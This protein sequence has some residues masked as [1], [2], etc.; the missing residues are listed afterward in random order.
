MTGRLLA[1]FCAAVLLV[2]AAAFAQ[3]AGN[4]QYS[5]P[6]A[7]KAPSTHSPTAP[8]SPAPAPT[9]SSPPAQPQGQLASGSSPGTTTQ[10][11]SGATPTA[12]SSSALPRTGFDAWIMAAM[13]ALMLLAGALLRLGLRAR[14]ASPAAASPRILGRDVRPVTRGR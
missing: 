3:S 6:F 14:P 4:E 9:T 8:S 10:G 12:S 1:A 11:N 13:G 2:P 5:D 7:G